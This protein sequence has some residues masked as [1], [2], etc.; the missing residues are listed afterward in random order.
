MMYD[1]LLTIRDL[2]T[3]FYTYRGVVKALDGVNLSISKREFAGL[4]GETGSGKSVT[5]LSIMRLIEPPGK[6]IS[7]EVIFNG[8]DLL[9]LSVEEVREIR[10][11]EISMI[12]QEPTLALNPVLTIGLQLREAIEISG[13]QKKE[14]ENLAI[15]MLK[16]VGLPDPERILKSYPHELSGGM[17][18]RVMIAMALS[19]KP[20]LLIA[21][22]PTS[23]LDVTVQAQIIDLMKKLVDEIGTSVLYITHDL[24]VAAEICDKIAVMY[25]GNIVEQ[26][27]IFTMF[28]EPLHPYTENLLKAIPKMGCDL[29]TIEGEVPDLINP[30]SG[31]RFHPRCQKALPIC[32]REKPQLV[33]VGKDHFVACHLFKY[34]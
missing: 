29:Y 21:D 14:A 1:K 8:R 11:K 24:G 17:A 9:K 28:E 12:F 4:V 34:K 10:G 31:C 22:E 5:A 19:L 7:G 26:S 33:E 25:A 32:L 30:P 23:S 20:K 18:Q 15:T 3:H 16:K 6:I 13:V 27:D 2:V